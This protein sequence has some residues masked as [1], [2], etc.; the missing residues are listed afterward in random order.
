MPSEHLHSDLKGSTI[1][2]SLG[3][4]IDLPW[5]AGEAG[6]KAHGTYSLIGWRAQNWH[7]GTKEVKLGIS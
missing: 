4:N 6:L 5:I 2:V 1:G 3:N 7:G